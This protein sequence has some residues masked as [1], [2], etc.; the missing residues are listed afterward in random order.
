MQNLAEQPD[1]GLPQL[2]EIQYRPL[3]GMPCRTSNKSTTKAAAAVR[4][5]PETVQ[6]KNIARSEQ[7]WDKLKD[8]A[9]KVWEGVSSRTDNLPKGMKASTPHPFPSAAKQK[10][11]AEILH[12]WRYLYSLLLQEDEG[13]T[14]EFSI[15]D[16]VTFLLKYCFG[17][18]L[19]VRFFPSSSSCHFLTRCLLQM[20]YANTNTPDKVKKSRKKG[21]KGRWI[22]RKD[23]PVTPPP[24][25]HFPGFVRVVAD[26]LRS[27][28]YDKAGY[29]DSLLISD[30]LPDGTRG[31]RLAVEVKP[32]WS[33]SDEAMEDVVSGDVA[34]PG[35]GQVD[36][37]VDDEVMNLLLQVSN[38]LS[39]FFFVFTLFEALG[40]ML[41]LQ[42]RLR[43]RH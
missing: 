43:F 4:L 19:R 24:N 34:I 28:E 7:L 31:N 29:P 10:R 32:F 42:R 8:Y 21:T 25:V 41:L 14:C 40:R 12:A 30:A 18:A 13:A 27:S 26:M 1:F 36:L 5:L 37:S 16:E 38:Y 17:P 35:T 22:N 6:I 2:P 3:Y 39:M 11:G 33:L 9:D 23:E 20:R 15:Q